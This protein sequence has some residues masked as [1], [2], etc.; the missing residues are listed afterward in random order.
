MLRVL[1]V[2]DEGPPPQCV[3][4]VAHG[5]KLKIVGPTLMPPPPGTTLSIPTADGCGQLGFYHLI[6]LCVLW[7]PLLAG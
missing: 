1:H 7:V 3:P 6:K 4:F 5:T 2:A